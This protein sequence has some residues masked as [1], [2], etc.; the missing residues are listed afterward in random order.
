MSRTKKELEE[1]NHLFRKRVSELEQI[2]SFQSNDLVPDNRFQS[3]IETNV[4]IFWETDPE[5]RFNYVSPQVKKYWNIEPEDVIGKRPIDLLI[6]KDRGLDSAEIEALIADHKPFQGLVLRTKVGDIESFVE[7]NGV[8]YF[9]T[10]GQFL[11]YRGITRDITRRIIAE[12]ALKESNRVALERLSEI[13]YLYHNIPM[14]LCELDL[15]LRFIRI[16]ER[17]AEI[18]GKSI[19]EHLGKKVEEVLP[20]LKGAA[21]ELK[22]KILHSGQPQLEVEISG[23]TPAQPGVLRSWSEDWLPLKDLSG[24]IT[25]INIVVIETTEKKRAE[26]ERRRNEERFRIMGEILPYGIW[27]CDADGK[28]IYTSASFLE[29]LNMTMEEMQGFGW[30]DRLVAEEREP[31]FQKWLHCV[32]TGEDWDHIHRIIDRN[33]NIQSVLT[34]GRPLYD[35]EGKIYAWA[36]INLD[37]NDRIASEKEIRNAKDA[38]EQS[39]KKLN[40]ALDNATIGLWELEVR[41]GIVSIDV[42][43]ERMFGLEPGSFDQTIAGIEN[44]IN[45]ED[46]NNVRKVIEDALYHEVPYEIIFRTKPI[47]GKVRYISAK[48]IAIKDQKGEVI[49]LSGV[50]FDITNLKEGTEQLISKLNLDLLRSNSDL[51]QFAY[52]ASHDLQEPLRMVAS[53]T[54]LL[55]K[56]YAGKLDQNANDYINFAVSGSKRMYE[57]IN[58]LLAYSRV[59]TKAERFTSV[60]MNSVVSKTKENLELL[61]IE[62][63]AKVISENLPDIIADESQMIQVMQNLIE[64]GIKFSN[65][66]PKIHVSSSQRED[67]WIFSVKDEGIGVEEQYYER[68]FRIFQKLHTHQEY[69]GTGI[70]L[71][72]CKRIVE[73]HGGEIWVESKPG[74]GAE[75]FFSIPCRKRPLS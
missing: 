55:Q 29:L 20:S 23:Y 32:R 16:N 37:I 61:I 73:R 5:A 26:Q 71:A 66:T 47:N 48:A 52:V 30:A 17:L 27:L 24:K 13:E 11:G 33:G 21:E 39:Q 68:I 9:A 36:G 70:G 69:K 65:E 22:N 51:Q 38:L 63:K 43:T 18:N 59:Q 34:R 35:E 4:D 3:I 62:S 67:M 75:F 74:M 44:L 10:T 57:L 58:G 25:G 60:S 1:E 41:T 7:V 54:Q 72:L 19:Q 49:N 8:P 45:E 14:G 56:Q 46:I 50:N 6:D 42:R 28:A 31:M 40:I 64:N 53:F 2:R 12:N 15:D